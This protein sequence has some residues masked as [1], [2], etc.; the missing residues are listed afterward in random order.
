MHVYDIIQQI[1]LTS[2]RNAKIDILKAHQDDEL[3]KRVVHHALDPMLIFYIVKIPPY[4]ENRTEPASQLNWAIDQL[5]VLAK[6]F[7]TGNAAQMHLSNLLSSLCFKD[8]QIIEMIIKK[9]LRCGVSISTANKVWPKM[10]LDYPC[11]LC[12]TLDD[13]TANAI[14]MPAYVQ[15]K[16]DG[17]R[18]NAI[19]RENA[20][21]YRSRNGKELYFHQSLDAYFVDMAAGDSVVFDGELLITRNGKILPRQTGNGILTKAIKGTISKQESEE[22][23]ATVWDCIPYIDF[24]SG[25]C[26]LT[27]EMRYA[28]LQK[29]MSQCTTSRIAIGEVEEVNDLFEVQ[30]AFEKRL[31][32]GEEGLILKDKHGVWEDKRVKHQVKYKGVYE[33]D[34][35][36]TGWEEGTGKNVGRLGAL[37]VQT[38]DGLMRVNV[39]SGFN[40]DDRDAIDRSVI[41]SIVAVKFNGL[42][43][44]KKTGEFSLFL[45]IFVEVRL[46]KSEADSLVMLKGISKFRD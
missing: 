10:L 13:D 36:V 45:P 20:V 7:V 37:S 17:M 32:A 4:N 14:H 40:D 39:G 11:M 46:D 38:S 42:I 24:I 8:A 12:A 26:K 28:R 23:C 34:L 25:K 18:F 3:L 41:G 35:L 29:Y 9:D 16:M 43:R 15:T 30:Q 5:D 6:R 27:Y 21:E 33:C 1:S 31:L 44:D 2:S 19:V 22:I